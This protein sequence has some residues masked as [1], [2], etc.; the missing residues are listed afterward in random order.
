[1]QNARRRRNA[2]YL[3][4]RLS[5]IPGI[6]TLRVPEY[7]TK[8][9]YHLFIFCFQEELF[10]IPR[11]DFIAALEKEDIRCSGGYAHPLYRNPM[12]LNQDFYPRGCPLTCGHYCDRIVDYGS[13]T[14][15]C[16]NAQRACREAVWLEQRLLLAEEDDMEDIARAILKIYECRTDFER[17]PVNSMLKK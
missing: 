9:S 16:P 3:T 11:R 15:L 7:V 1:M 2:A 10:G 6:A 4:Q 5:G 14:R 17:Q 8:H 13:F 12:L